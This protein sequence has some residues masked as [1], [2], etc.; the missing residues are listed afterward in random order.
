MKSSNDVFKVTLRM[1]SREKQCIDEKAAL[2]KKSVNRYLIDL[3]L[4]SE[5]AD[6]A[7]LFRQAQRLVHLQRQIDAIEHEVKKQE[8]RRECAAVWSGFVF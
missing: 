4:E 2:A 1:S 5:T 3:A 8:L 7:E 6:R